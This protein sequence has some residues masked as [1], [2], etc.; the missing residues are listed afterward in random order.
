[1]WHKLGAKFKDL[2]LN[3]YHVNKDFS[4]EE[5]SVS[6]PEY[7]NVDYIFK[8]DDATLLIDSQ[9]YGNAVLKYDTNKFN[10]LDFSKLFDSNFSSIA[11]FHMVAYRTINKPLVFTDDIS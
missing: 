9:Y 10:L 8:H 11:Y 2:K 7:G 3:Y 1:M 4:T 6:S 5:L